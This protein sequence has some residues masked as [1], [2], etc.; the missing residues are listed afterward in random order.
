MTEKNKTFDNNGFEK[1][2]GFEVYN[3][4]FVSANR[5]KE[6]S[7]FSLNA[8]IGNI[9]Y[10]SK[11]YLAEFLIDDLSDRLALDKSCMV[12]YLLRN[13]L[14]V[15]FGNIKKLREAECFELPLGS[16]EYQKSISI[17]NW[18]SRITSRKNELMLVVI[19]DSKKEKVIS[20]LSEI[21]SLEIVEQSRIEAIVKASIKSFNIIQKALRLSVLVGL[22]LVAFFGSKITNSYAEAMQETLKE[23]K[24]VAL[25]EQRINKLS[26][27]SL[28]AENIQLRNK[29]YKFFAPTQQ[30]ITKDFIK[31]PSANF[32][33]KN[34]EYINQDNMEKK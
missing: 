30:K 2:I 12:L 33:I 31:S 26:Y 18:Y 17:I 28:K 20:S 6:K 10:S 13:K 23:N 32:T 22:M 19:H 5:E 9:F 3:K 7:E 25:K 8:K 4:L 15:S 29:P 1:I 21:C 14:I 27:D 11:N 16:K 24:R 34:G